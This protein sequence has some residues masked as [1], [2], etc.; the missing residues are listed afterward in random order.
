MQLAMFAAVQLHLHDQ[1]CAL[2]ARGDVRSDA[3]ASR[4]PAE[5]RYLIAHDEQR[6]VADVAAGPLEPNARAS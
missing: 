4:P 1:V 3:T 5:P 2:T 6:A